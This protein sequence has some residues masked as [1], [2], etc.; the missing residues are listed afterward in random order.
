MKTQIQDEI[1][2]MHL[3]RILI[4]RYLDAKI[5]RTNEEFETYLLYR[6]ESD[7]FSKKE[8]KRAI[9][10]FKSQIYPIDKKQVKWMYDNLKTGNYMYYDIAQQ[11]KKLKIG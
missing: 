6:I 3:M 2:F 11:I 8:I 9:K 4:W 7:N 10:H 5:A 1:D